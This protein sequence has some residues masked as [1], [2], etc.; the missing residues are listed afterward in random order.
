LKILYHHRTLGDGAEGIHIREMVRAF[1]GL[2]HEVRVIGPAGEAE[3]HASGR[4]QVLGSIKQMIPTVAFEL[5]EISYSAYAFVKTAFE[6]AR[7][8][9]DFVYD[10]YITFNAG[11]VLAARACGVRVLL[12]VNAPLALERAAQRDER[13]ILR[14][15]AKA[16]ERWIC[17]QPTRTIV[18]ST[19]LK[20]YLESLGVPPGQCYVMPNGV[21]PNKFAPQPKDQALLAEL[22]IAAGSLVIGFTGVLREWHGLDL[23]LEAAAH[24]TA[25]RFNITVL[26]V[27]DG[28]YRAEMQRII[29]RL[30]LD[31][32]VVI[33]G[34][35][36][37]A[38]VPAYVSL[39]DVAVSPRA[40]FY[41]SPMKVVEYMALGK[42]VV[43]PR[44]QNFL[45]MID[46]GVNGVTFA[47]ADPVA[48]ADALARIYADP[49]ICQDLGKSARRKVETRLNW[50]WNAQRSC[51]LAQ[52]RQRFASQPE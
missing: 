1:R 17:S 49:E 36:A 23:L 34:R 25:Q 29:E 2:G 33:T 24:L 39:F 22:K 30:K 10:R 37:H 32:R 20:D 6:I 21:D 44:T 42:A 11:V 27:G 14:R 15:L 48:L 38:R 43:V 8:R 19:P 40:T 16:F 9:P 26:V 45:D 50:R 52:G 12:E 46:D 18:V 41:A 5:M 47:D 28:P 3:P 31:G 35:V 13:L 4:S 7:W 51:E